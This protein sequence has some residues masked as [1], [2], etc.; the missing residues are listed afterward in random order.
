MK[1]HEVFNKTVPIKWQ[2][3]KWDKSW[4][5]TF[6]VG[7]IVYDL[8]I[9]FEEAEREYLIMFTAGIEAKN[10]VK[11]SSTKITKTGNEFVV[12]A[13]VIKGIEQFIKVEQPAAFYFSA[14]EPSRRK[15]YDRMAKI[16][17]RKFPYERKSNSRAGYYE[18]M[19]KMK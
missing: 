10:K 9:I 6:K 4:S 1:L 11:S 14:S 17:P 3:K 15:L 16:I 5:G 7:D 12:F 18:F 8:E 19:R 2:K 13:T